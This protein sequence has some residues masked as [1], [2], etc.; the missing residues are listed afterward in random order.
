MINFTHLKVLIKKDFITLWRS[1]G[2]L[3]SFILMPVI[4]MESFT[5]IKNLVDDGDKDGHLI[6]DYFRYTST[7]QF[8]YN[9]RFYDY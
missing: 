9:Q 3:I 2:F 4:L 7:L 6:Y 8:P 5:F 1:K